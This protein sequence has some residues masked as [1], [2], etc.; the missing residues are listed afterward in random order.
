MFYARLQER[1]CSYA[2]ESDGAAKGNRRQR[3][4]Y[5]ENQK[6]KQISRKIAQLAQLTCDRAACQYMQCQEGHHRAMQ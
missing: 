6:G 5:Q 2:R 4:I 1:V 3:L